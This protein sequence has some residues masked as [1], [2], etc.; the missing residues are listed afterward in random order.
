MRKVIAA[1]NISLDGF[2][3]HTMGIVNDELHNHY[4]EM[5]QYAGT[6]LYGRTTYQLMESYWPELVKN[7]SGDQSSD[8]FAIAIDNVQKVVFSRTLK[9]VAWKNTTLAT[10]ALKDEV[11]ALRE[12]PGNDIFVGSPGLIAQLTELHLIDE[13]QLAVHPVIAGHGLPLFKNISDTI[14]LNRVKTKTFTTGVMVH[15]YQPVKK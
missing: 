12:Q 3:D 9:H 11:L 8:D 13:Y 6:L 10:R 14:V 5:I 1:M 15:W 2:C 4:T 7:P